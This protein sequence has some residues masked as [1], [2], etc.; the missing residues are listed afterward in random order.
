MN[1]LYS[2]FLFGC[3]PVFSQ[4]NQ[5]AGQ[6]PAKT[7]TSNKPVIGNNSLLWEIS[8]R[9][10][11]RSSYLYGTMHILC[12]TD[13]GISPRLKE[14]IKIAEQ[15]YFEVDMDDMNE[16][17]GML[18][19]ARMNN[20]LKIADLVSPEE[21]IRIQEYFKSIKTPIPFAMMAR[22]KPYFVAAVI[23]ESIMECE[24]KSSMEQ[25]IMAEARKGDKEILGLETI[26][27]QAS[28]FDSIPYEKQARDLVTYVDSIESYRKNAAEMIEIYRNQ[29]ID[30]MDS[31][32]IRSDPGMAEYM[33]ML[34]YT[35]NIRWTDTINEQVFNKPTIFAVGAG[36]LGGEKGV[37]ALLKK[38][39]FT[40]KPLPNDTKTQ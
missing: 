7:S 1:F 23:S 5:P 13:A 28:L 21:Y 19:H 4:V 40:L 14:A 26:S 38:R 32:L 39:G 24:Q 27:F 10:L 12:S 3:L 15:V 33:D 16:M 37:I 18:N 25:E 20:G 29:E 8:G 35:R 9:G 36:H 6:P 31:L 34:L 2:I 11:E 30:K 22:F 17:L